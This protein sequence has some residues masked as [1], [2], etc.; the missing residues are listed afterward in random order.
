MNQPSKLF[1]LWILVDKIV[2]CQVR[3]DICGVFFI[4]IAYKSRIELANICYNWQTE[5]NT[6]TYKN[7]NPFMI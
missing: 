4:H 6:F 3:P 5:W 7:D 2:L 1:S